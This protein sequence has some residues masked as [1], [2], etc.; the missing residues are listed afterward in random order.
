MKRLF[1]FREGIWRNWGRDTFIALRGLLLLTGRFDE[2]RHLLLTYGSCLRHG[3]IPNLLAGPRYNARD[4]IWFW[5]Y[6]LAQYTELAPDG[7]S[8]LSANIQGN[9]LHSIIKTAMDAHLNG[10]SFREHNAGDQLDR[11]MSDE[12]FNNRIGID[13][14]TGFVVGGNRW[15]CGTW[16]DKMGSSDV[17][18]N[19]GH[20]GSP[21]DGSAI[22]LVGL[23][24]AT[25]QWL[26]KMIGKGF[27]PYDGDRP[28][29]EAWLA[30][31]DDNFERAFWIDQNRDESPHVNRRNIYKDTVNSTLQWTDYQFRPNFLVAAVVVSVRA[32]SI[33]RSLCSL[34]RLLKCSTKITSG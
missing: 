28:T 15:N 24:R 21:R 7:C 26:I 3:L 23:S 33:C 2:A 16:M 18:R 12:G 20:P 27:Y 31:I 32:L 22:E 30:K 5:L 8:I 17:A 13:S 14:L 11:V 19:K 10:L 4:A 6:S 25:I 9:S 34:S 29:L 1:I